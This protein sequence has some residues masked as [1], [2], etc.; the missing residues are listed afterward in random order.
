MNDVP[1]KRTEHEARV[2]DVVARQMEVHDELVRLQDDYARLRRERDLLGQRLEHA[3]A[4]NQI[5]RAERDHYMVQVATFLEQ[6]N[7][8]ST[9]LCQLADQFR[10]AAEAAVNAPFNKRNRAAEQ[11]TNGQAE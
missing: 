1:S 7:H 4:D 11:L 2:R 9:G 3:E 10:I 6:F 5:L 8:T